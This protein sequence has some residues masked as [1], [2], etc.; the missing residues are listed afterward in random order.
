[1]FRRMIRISPALTLAL[2]L[3]AGLAAL[4][5]LA[6]TQGD[7]LTGR[8]L[9]GW[10]AAGGHYM[11]AISLTLSPGWHTY[12]RSPGETGIPPVFDWSASRNLKSVA[13]HWPSP[14]VIA[15]NGSISIGYLDGLTL[16]VEVVP[17]DPAQPVELA[18]KLDLG[19]CHDICVPAALALNATLE[20][21][22]AADRAIS[23]ALKSGPQSGASAGVTGLTCDV[24]AIDDGLR[25][26]A[27]LQMPAQGDGAGETVV[28]EAG[29]PGVW[30]SSAATDRQGEAL[31]AIADLVPPVGKP[32]ALDRSGLVVTVLAEGR[33]VEMRGCPA[34]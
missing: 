3:A 24:A 19:V 5:A 33:S 18:L 28:I 1:M 26:T 2:A 21:P 16:P 11:A 30:V 15:Q 6:Q 4:P 14:Q 22:G 9:P 12:W 29:E 27:R 23:A 34:P 13:L 7:V 20:G 31:S 17:I 10:R 8:V 25:V 32:F